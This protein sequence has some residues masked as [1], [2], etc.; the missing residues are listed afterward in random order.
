MI[1]DLTPSKSREGGQHI[2]VFPR[3]AV[4]WTRIKAVFS[5]ALEY[6]E[7]G[8]SAYLNQTCGGEAALRQEVESLLASEAAASGWMETPAAGLL[9]ALTEAAPVPRLQPGTRLGAYEIINFIAAGGMGEVYH[10][11]HTVLGREAAVKILGSGSNVEAAGRRLLREARHASTLA[12]PNICTIYDVGETPDGPFIAMEYVAGRLLADQIRDQLPTLQVAIELGLQIADALAHAHQRGIIHRDLK[13]SNIIV[14]IEG[15]PIVLDF[16]LARRLPAMNESQTRL[17]TLTLNDGL[18]G[19]P[20]HMAPE[21][22]LGGPADARSDVWALGVVLYE[23]LTGDLPFKGKTLYETG[24]AIVE[25]PPRR[26]STHIPLALRLVIERCLSKDPNRRYQSAVEVRSALALFRRRRTWSLVIP[27]LISLR[28]RQLLRVA[29]TMVMVAAVVVTGPRL[30]HMLR[31]STLRISSMAVLPLENGSG[32]RQEQYYA[33]GLTDGLISQLGDLTEVNII[34]RASA[35]RLGGMAKSRMQAARQIGVDVILEGTVRRVNERITLDLRLIEPARA[36]V[37]W[38][39][40]FERTERD[41]LVM[42]ADAVRELARAMRLAVRSEAADRL[43]V[44]RAVNP[45]AYEAYLK[46]RYEWNHRTPKSVQRAIKF[47]TQAIELDPTYSPAH[48]ALADCYNQLATVMVSS[49]SPR[50]WRPRAEA[51]AIKALQLDPY[52]AEAHATLG[53]VRHYQW[54]WSEAENE[55]RRALQ[56]NPS[57]S[58][59]RIWFANLLMSRNRMSEALQQVFA[60]RDLDPFSLTVNTN[61]GWVLAVSG[62]FD[63]AITQLVRT[64]QLDSTYVQ[65]HERLADA[66]GHAGRMVEAIEE[67]QRVV[68]LTNRSSFSLSG[69]AIELAHNNQDILAR[70]VLAELETRSEHEYVSPWTFALVYASLG[71]TES[72]VTWTERAFEE[73]SNGIAYIRVDPELAALRNHPRIRRLMARAGLE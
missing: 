37:I 54:Q 43:A 67:A 27:L 14:S 8:R 41:V 50:E 47:Y 59:A 1:P 71:D 70:T 44:V 62:R 22:L 48:A 56:L 57:L 45:L 33:D 63:D 25:E 5:E 11:R 17:S 2:P 39:E 60:A 10:A 72:A 3:E 24:S 7:D 9:P 18:V 49:G 12:H 30:G 65:A 42:Q 46:G 53:Y 34:P 69:L 61:V 35:E 29:A 51:E 19:T 28:Q 38:S 52:S 20:S 21:V 6:P 36:R 16:G 31:G 4:R 58:L 55:F 66:F 26:L 40:S 13:C 23:V 15:R 64:L 73:G 68:T 32:Q